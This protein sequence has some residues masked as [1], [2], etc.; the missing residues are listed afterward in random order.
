MFLCRYMNVLK[1]EL[2]KKNINFTKAIR[3]RKCDEKQRKGIKS[4][5]ERISN[6]NLCL[7]KPKLCYG[8]YCNM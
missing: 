8:N 6:E 2:H 4:R 3:K 5:C 7:G 1:Y